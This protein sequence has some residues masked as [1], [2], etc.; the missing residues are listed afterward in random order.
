MPDLVKRTPLGYLSHVDLY[1]D[2]L[3]MSIHMMKKIHKLQEVGLVDVD[4][5]V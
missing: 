3:K 4:N 5:Y 1:E 2:A